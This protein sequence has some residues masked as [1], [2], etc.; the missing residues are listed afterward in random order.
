VIGDVKVHWIGG[1]TWNSACVAFLSG[2]LLPIDRTTLAD[3]KAATIGI[4]ALFTSLA[5]ATLVATLFA[6]EMRH[7]PA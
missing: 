3:F 1:T 6:Q 7:K 2:G 4:S 5:A